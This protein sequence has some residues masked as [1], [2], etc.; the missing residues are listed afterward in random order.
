MRRQYAG[1]AEI[2]LWPCKRKEII[3]YD[4]QPKQVRDWALRLVCLPER[5]FNSELSET[6]I[7]CRFCVLGCPFVQVIKHLLQHA[8]AVSSD[9]SITFRG[10][11]LFF[12]YFQLFSHKR[13]HNILCGLNCTC[14]N[15]HRIVISLLL[16]I[17]NNWLTIMSP[18]IAKHV[19]WIASFV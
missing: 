12:S 15:W 14:T 16:I 11:T 13:A 3:H 19:S 17:M 8:S 1:F 10:F 5:T 9:L 6:V 4:N 7:H 2:N 18:I